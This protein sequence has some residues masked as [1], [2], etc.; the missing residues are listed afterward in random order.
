MFDTLGGD[1]PFT[2]FAPNDSAFAELGDETIAALLADAENLLAPI[3]TYH[4][5]GAEVTKGDL[6]SGA[7]ET[8]NGAPVVANVGF[9]RTK[10]NGARVTYFDLKGSNGVVHIVSHRSIS[11]PQ[12]NLRS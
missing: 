12:S 7:V 5:A 6:E 4:V 8:L 1:G 9:F 2:V 3:L 10:I 11:M